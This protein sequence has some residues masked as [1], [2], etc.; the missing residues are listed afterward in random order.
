MVKIKYKRIPFNLELAKKI[1]NRE[2]KG[3]IVTRRGL[4]ARIICFDRKEIEDIFDPPKNIIALI[5]NKDGNE[6]VFEVRDTGMILLNE[7]TDYDLIIEVPTYRRDYFNFIPQKWHAY[8]VRDFNC[9][10]WVIRV[11]NGKD[12]YGDPTFFNTSSTFHYWNHILPLNN[13]TKR[14]IGTTKSYEQL[15]EE[16]DAE[17]NKNKQ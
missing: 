6:G 4:K 15:M 9:D 13:V 17:L 8:V 7:E 1:S 12:S 2:I 5:E 11:C 10:I 16:L 3:N 14:L